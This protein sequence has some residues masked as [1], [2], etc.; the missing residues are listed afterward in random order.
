MMRDWLARVLG[1]PTDD[2]FAE[3]VRSHL[4][5]EIDEQ[6]DRGLPPEEARYAAI[7]RFGNVTRHLERF[8]EASPAFWFE[9]LW[10]D[11]QIGWR[12]LGR[13]PVLSAIAILSLGL[14]IGANTSVYTVARAVLL[15]PLGVPDA[16]RMFVIGAENNALSLMPSVTPA[17]LDDI[18]QLA[19]TFGSAGL[20]TF[21]AMTVKVS[22]GL[23]RESVLFANKE[24]TEAFGV[25]PRLGRWPT[26]E[27]YRSGARVAVLTDRLWRQYW[28]DAGI[29][30]S[31]MRLLV[32]NSGI[33]SEVDFTIIGVAPPSLQGLSVGMP[34]GALLP[35]RSQEALFPGSISKAVLLNGGMVGRLAPGQS[36]ANAAQK[37]AAWRLP[38]RG[39]Q[40]TPRKLQLRPAADAALPNDRRIA[41]VRALGGLAGLAGIVLLLGCSNLAS[42]MLA[43]S[44]ARRHELA[45]RVSLGASR[46]RLVRLLVV[47]YL[48]IAVLSTAAALALSQAMVQAFPASVAIGRSWLVVPIEVPLEVTLHVA[49]FAAAL[50]VASCLTFGLVPALR[51]TWVDPMTALRGG[52]QARHTARSRPRQLLLAA[53]VAASSLLL[54]G[55]LLLGHAVTDGTSIDPGYG[56]DGHLLY[57]RVQ[58]GQPAEAI[59]ML[60]RRIV[61]Q[62]GA[63]PSFM[64]AAFTSSTLPFGPSGVGDRIM[65]DG[66]ERIPVSR[67]LARNMSGGR[68]FAEF[69]EPS[70]RETLGL[71]L[72]SGRDLQPADGNSSEPG[73]L[74]NEALARQLWPG[75]GG[76]GSQIRVHGLN[77]EWLPVNASGRILGVVGN[78]RYDVKSGTAPCV[79]IV[80]DGVRTNG[81]YVRMR[82]DAQRATAAVRQVLQAVQ[83]DEPPPLVL[84]RDDYVRAELAAERTL[85]Q[86]LAWFAGIAL[87]LSVVGVYGLASDTVAQRT[88]E[89]AIRLALGSP[90]GAVFRLVTRSALVSTLA[91]LA[92]GLVG[93]ALAAS[94]ARAF[95]FGLEPFRPSAYSSAAVLILGVAALGL[96]WPASRAVKIAP[97]ETLRAE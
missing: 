86:I 13:T 84:S 48:L 42:A 2:Q 95:V 31:R 96:W 4:A 62:L 92:V 79:Y 22:G 45:M 58:L 29:L 83:P 32:Q 77:Q 66:I 3:E 91:G 90:E 54:A 88:R 73:V 40:A 71:P 20:Y 11:V 81:L 69:I 27:E 12:S 97:A 15:D 17:E 49:A 5:H 53:Q 8:R 18:V 30:G 64:A 52:R 23:T 75:G 70:F 57:A 65:V 16:D 61:E 63:E 24:A 89:I 38:P 50:G 28:A 47:E 67:E 82:D 33:I 60:R 1:R 39:P 80:S 9:T 14:G 76:I 21:R 72:L 87:V 25:Q 51:S 26:D 59:P 85:L 56:G 68:V 35:L 19:G 74:V 34:Y 55:A 41:L 7:R 46:S 93:A 36:M 43:R 78:A 37:V 10:Q 44:G 94:A 6:V